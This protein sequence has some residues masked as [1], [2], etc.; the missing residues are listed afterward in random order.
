V[1]FFLASGQADELFERVVFPF[2]QL[3]SLARRR[4]R[5]KKADDLLEV[6]PFANTPPF[7]VGFH[8]DAVAPRKRYSPS[9][10]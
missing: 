9:C 8:V 1:F 2:S 10:W 4:R 7:R 3:T 5:L 6:L